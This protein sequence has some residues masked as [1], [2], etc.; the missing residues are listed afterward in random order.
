MK[1]EETE[2]YIDIPSEEK[3]YRESE[4]TPDYSYIENT[5]QDFLS[6][7]SSAINSMQDEDCCDQD[8]FYSSLLYIRDQSHAFHWQT[9]SNSEH[10]AFGKYYEKYSDL[11][12]DLVETI[13]GATGK[14]PV[15]NSSMNIKNYSEENVKEF[16]D[17]VEK[18]I[19]EDIPN[20]I[21]PVY[22]EVYNLLDEIMTETQRLKYRLS[23]R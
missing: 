7:I 9:F 11:L 10:F 18:I 6:I 14:R 22:T 5:P 3:P 4:Y 1:R 15:F 16:L 12:D 23:L 20:N 19:R 13:I 21:D 8:P 2:F 17:H